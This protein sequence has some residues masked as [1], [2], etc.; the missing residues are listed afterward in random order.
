MST[1]ST[2][3]PWLTSPTGQVIERGGEGEIRRKI[4]RRKCGEGYRAEIE[5][6]ARREERN[7]R[8]RLLRNGE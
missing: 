7:Y 3:V 5:R 2:T 6:S 4:Q 8:E 1:M